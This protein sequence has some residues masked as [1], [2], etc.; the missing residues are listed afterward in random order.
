MAQR[1]THECEDRHRHD[2]KNCEYPISVKCWHV[3][4]VEVEY[5][6]QFSMYSQLQINSIHIKAYRY[7][8]ESETWLNA[9]C[10][11]NELR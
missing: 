6:F 4:P 7:S 10:R 2:L 5:Q 3:E 9:I 1:D 11:I 8:D